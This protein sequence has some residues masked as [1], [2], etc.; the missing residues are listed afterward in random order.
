MDRKSFVDSDLFT[1]RFATQHGDF[2][3]LEKSDSNNILLYYKLQN[4]NQYKS[5]YDRIIII[6]KSFVGFEEIPAKQHWKSAMHFYDKPFDA[7]FHANERNIATSVLF[8][9]DG[10]KTVLEK[11][12]SLN[13]WAKNL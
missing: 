2:G 11:M 3:F 4:Q 9:L 6:P 12:K 7:T 1:Y 8:E 10:D 5:D 13:E